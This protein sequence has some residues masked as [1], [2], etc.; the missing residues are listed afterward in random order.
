MLSCS[1]HQLYVS[2]GRASAV[3]QDRSAPDQ[4]TSA[5]FT[6]V[7]YHGCRAVSKMQQKQDWPRI[8]IAQTPALTLAH[9][10]AV[11]CYCCLLLLLVIVALLLL[12]VTVALLLLL[13][14]V[15][16]LLLLVTVACYCCL[17][18][19]LV[20]AACYC[21][22]VTAACYCCLLLLLVTVAGH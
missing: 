10:T 5:H 21:C 1:G 2:S 3:K 9:A 6:A 11:G 15:A 8:G 12:L 16:L 14:T 18:L 17:L 20:T 7:T 22:F 13:V 19:L 4:L